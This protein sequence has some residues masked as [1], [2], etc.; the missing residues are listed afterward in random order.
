MRIAKDP[1][2]YVLFP[3]EQKATDALFPQVH[4]QKVSLAIWTTTPWTLPLNRAVLIKPD[5]QYALLNINDRYVVVGAQLADKLVAHLNVQKEVIALVTA[6]AFIKAHAH[7]QHPFIE[8]VIVP[9]IPSNTVSSDEGTAFVHCAPGCG[10]E[11]YEVGIKHNLEIF[12]PVSVEGKY[13]SGIAPHEL[14]GM[15]V[16]DGQI[17]VIKTLA[18]RNALLYKTS[19]KH[20][21]PH[22][23]RCH[24]GLI[25]RATKQWF[26]DLSKHDLKERVIKAIDGVNTYPHNSKNR[27][28]ATVEGRLEWCLSRQRIWGYQFPRC[29]A[30]HAIMCLSIAH[31]SRAW[32]SSLA[33]A[34]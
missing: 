2:I 1:S 11:D 5:A 27:L 23:W 18:A 28:L 9:I 20:S 8:N 25:F 15:S 10:P 22:C 7:A 24:N 32:L 31:L 26:C 16:T 13:T 17:W 6:D 29:C 21:Y 12:S 30:P 14:E 4:G 19:I 3:L 33:Y 34:A